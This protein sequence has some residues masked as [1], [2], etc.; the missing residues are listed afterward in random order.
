[1]MIQ[2]RTFAEVVKAL[3]EARLVDAHTTLPARVVSYD[4]N[5]RTASVQPIVRAPQ[6]R[7][8]GTKLEA[9]PVLSRVPVMFQCTSRNGISFPIESGDL[10]WVMFSEHS[11]AGVLISDGDV[12]DPKSPAR[13]SLQGAVCI[14]G[15]HTLS[16][17]SDQSDDNAMV[18]HGDSIKLGSKSASQK[19]ALVPG[20]Q[21]ALIMLLTDQN[22]ASAMFAYGTACNAGVPAA[23]AA[24]LANLLVALEQY[25]INNPIQGAEKVEAE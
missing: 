4:K 18:V 3:I 10:V 21:Q 1:M 20:V 11:L 5:T 25:F 23:I 6:R 22:V 8:T 15:F 24:A 19:V 17:V 2:Q 9:L 12:S 14:P 7:E 16:A 13:F